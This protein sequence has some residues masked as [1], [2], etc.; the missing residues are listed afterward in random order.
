[1]RKLLPAAAAAPAVATVVPCIAST[2][3]LC[4][5]RHPTPYNMHYIWPALCSERYG[6]ED[7][8]WDA[9]QLVLQLHWLSRVSERR[10]SLIVH[11]IKLWGLFLSTMLLDGQGLIK[12]NLPQPAS[13]VVSVVLNWLTGLRLSPKLHN[14]PYVVLKLWTK[15]VHYNLE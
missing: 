6:E 11:Q 8:V 7:A 12:V 4:P 14:I 5:K 13:V 2:Q 15:V 9:R 10:A 1:M 3:W